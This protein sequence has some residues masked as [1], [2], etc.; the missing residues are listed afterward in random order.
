[1]ARVNISPVL[2]PNDRVSAPVQVLKRTAATASTFPRCQS[3]PGAGPARS[4]PSCAASWSGCWADCVGGPG[5]RCLTA[6]SWRVDRRRPGPRPRSGRPA[7]RIRMPRRDLPAEAT[8]C[9]LLTRSAG[10]PVQD[11]E[12]SQHCRGAAGNSKV[13]ALTTAWTG[14]NPLR[15]SAFSV[16]WMFYSRWMV[17]SS[18][19]LARMSGAS[20]IA[21]LSNFC[22]S[23]PAYLGVFRACPSLS[24]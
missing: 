19:A 17:N 24:K 8:V 10:R 3:E 5:R 23:I 22:S 21:T 12:G 20:C 18:R 16:A 14:V 6:G 9:R 2:F 4:A 11:A 1:M 13:R 15:F 7:A